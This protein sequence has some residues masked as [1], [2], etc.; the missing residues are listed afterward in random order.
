MSNLPESSVFARA[1]DWIKARISRDNELAVLS[2]ADM[3][4]LAADIGISE[5]DFRELAPRIADHSGQMDE[6]MVLRGLD[7]ERVRQAFSAVVRDME[8]T[9]ALCPNPGLCRQRLAD[10]SA[11]ARAREFCPNAETM[12]GF[13]DLRVV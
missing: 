3:Q 1:F 4:N 6:M 2:T 7:P 5:S 9:C 13:P 8:L 11:A 10:G 12:E